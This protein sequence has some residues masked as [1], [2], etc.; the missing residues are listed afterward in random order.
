MY[1]YKNNIINCK[2]KGVIAYSHYIV[3][4]ECVN[5]MKSH[6]ERVEENKMKRCKA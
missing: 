1:Y 5:E 2:N 6:D 3:I 4:D